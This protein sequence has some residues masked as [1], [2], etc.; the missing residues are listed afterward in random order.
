VVAFDRPV[1]PGGY[2]WW[3]VDA[4]SDD[5]ADALT[6]I[7]FVGSVFSPYYAWSGRRDPEDHVAINVALYRKGGGRWAMTERGRGSVHRSREALQ[8]GPSAFRWD[9]AAL[10]V[11]VDEVGFPLPRRVRGRVRVVP[12]VRCDVPRVLEE[13]GQHRWWPIAPKCR[14]EVAFE[15]P[16]VRWSGTG[17]FDC[18]WGAAPL[19]E[20]FER[21]TWS[22]APLRDGA[23]VLYDV[24]PRRGPPRALA[25][26]FDAS[27]GVHEFEPPPLA[28]LPSS[29]FLI[30]RET[31]SEGPAALVRTLTDAP[32]YARSVVRSVLCGE[33]TL[34]VHESLSLDRASAWWGR[35]LLPF[36]MPRRGG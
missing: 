28:R 12:E 34:G 23:A 18:N 5:G 25:L 27:G 2:A 16:E 20:G 7:G 13:A 8:V 32:F 21:W 4:L 9:G 36:R 31:R 29:G 1:P 11:S 26:R 35:L 30:S 10:E 17:Y 22:R 14:V 33:E 6:L 19:E 3:Y 24:V 15:A